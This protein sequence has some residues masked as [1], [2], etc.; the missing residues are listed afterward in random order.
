MAG[1]KLQA[2][3][4]R[5]ARCLAVGFVGGMLISPWGGATSLRADEVDAGPELPAFAG[6]SSEET[7]PYIDEQSVVVE[8]EPL[9]DESDLVIGDAEAGGEDLE[10]LEPIAKESEREPD[11][12]D[13]P[14]GDP[15][16]PEPT[17]ADDYAAVAT[18]G[19]SPITPTPLESD[20]QPPTDD[21]CIDEALSPTAPERETI[22]KIQA[23]SFNGVTP[24]VTTRAEVLRAWGQPTSS[25]SRGRTIV[26]Q[27][28]N[29]PAITLSL[30]SDV[31]QLVEVDLPIAADAETLIEKLGL[32]TLRPAVATDE[33]GAPIATVF[34]ERG[35]TLGHR[36]TELGE[37]AT[38]SR[39]DTSTDRVYEIV[40]QPI[41]AEGFA[42]RAETCSARDYTGRIADLEEAL[43]LDPHD[44]RARFLLSQAKLA[45]GA[46][47]TAETLASEAVDLEPRNYE[48]R[49]H[50]ARC[51]KCLARYDQAVQETRAVLDAANAHPLLRAAA[52]EQMAL[53]ATVGTLEVQKR[54]A[55]L[56]EKTIE[57]AD[58]IAA[59]KNPLESAAATQILIGAHLAMAERIAVG[60]WKEKDKFVGQWIARA[61]ALA[62]Q[63]IADGAGDVSLRLQV[64]VSALA[65]AS[66]FDST[67]NPQPWV[68][69][70][71]EAVT[72]LEED[73]VDALALAEL[74]WQLGLAYFYAAEISHRAAEAGK[75]LEYGE[76]A[77]ES[78]VRGAASR[79]ELPD[80]QF[81]LGRVYFQVGAVHAVLR[82]NHQEACRW[83]DRAMEPLSL[84]TPV[85]P[86]AAPGVHGDALVSMAVSYWETGDRDRAYELTAAGA[87]LVEQSIA[88]ELLP[89]SALEVPRNNYLA[90]A[91]ALGKVAMATPAV[92]EDEPPQ[93][94]QQEQAPSKRASRNPG[95]QQRQMRTATRRNTTSSNVRR[96]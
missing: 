96:R 23:A 40:L 59:S 49:L 31:V 64:S 43:R 13:P 12:A 27:Q 48:Y 92:A 81:M 57:M 19:A 65:A 58:K 8:S 44:G 51:L 29:Y 34:P 20:E 39:D 82:G 6:D 73:T 83:Y 47:I 45:T 62:E 35:V 24:G 9:P 75:A 16:A 90:M 7:P 17:L 72:E 91:R 42:L 30:R 77:E 94:A 60:D 63:L 89:A 3:R 15:D 53:L 93:V 26:Y 55:P 50:W 76:L 56:I 85:T 21:V 32:A 78:L 61:S 46:A 33:H 74:E 4:T 10:P 80:T 1:G 88:E 69:E 54:S 28:P 71:E 52:T 86:L 84:P 18:D 36:P 41:N 70:A 14:L 37:L 22:A 87:Q 68:T 38:D 5:C 25:V 95:G 2:A 79:G 67:V 11:L 66:K